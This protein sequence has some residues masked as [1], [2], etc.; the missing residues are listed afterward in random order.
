MPNTLKASS[1]TPESSLHTAKGKAAPESSRGEQLQELEEALKALAN[2]NQFFETLIRGLPGIFYCFN[3]KLQVLR[4]NRNVETVTG[5]TE[6]EVGSISLLTLFKG[7]DKSLIRNSIKDVFVNGEGLA[8]STIVTKDGR[9]IPYMFTGVSTRI[10]GASYLMGM[11]LD[12]SARKAAEQ[13]LRE[14][15]ALYR[16]LGERITEGVVL[17]HK[18]RFLFANEAAAS[19]FGYTREEFLAKTPEFMAAEPFRPYFLELYQ[20]LESGA[21]EERTFQA[22]C[23]HKLGNELWVEGKAN[24]ITWKGKP[25]LL[26]TARDVTET[27]LRELSMQEEAE[28]LRRENVNLRSSMRDRYR[29]G[30]I[31]GKSTAMQEVYELILNAAAGSANVIIYGESGTGKE[32]VARAIH[33]MS[34]RADQPFVPVNCAAIPANLLESEFFGSRKGAFTGAHS[35]KEGFLD[36]ANGG[37]LFLD[38]VGELD[39][40]LQV[41]LL[42]AIEGGGYTPVGGNAVKFS[43]FRIIAATNRNLLEQARAGKMREDFF[44]RIHIIP[45]NLP[46]LRQRRDDI[47]L[48]AEHFMKVYSGGQGQAVLPGKVLDDLVA[49]DWPG[50]VRELQNVIQR[51]LTVNRLDFISPEPVQA[52]APLSEAVENGADLRGATE[53]VEKALIKKALDQN[54][55]HKSR[56]AESLG[57]SR[58]TLFRK[59]RRLGLS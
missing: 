42:R 39:I 29:F 21:A 16:L 12:I 33:K 10:N 31:I 47:P 25:S 5:Y 9:K 18:N 59:M 57:I 13:S 26:L 27:K 11:G 41:K 7:G 43:D 14:S 8:E 56:T 38:E 32:L 4:W 23:L 24:F 2:E 50:N 46:P 52:K 34:K 17:A 49:Y 40:M 1:K 19:M 36:Q 30:N 3:D 22:R 48:L 54:R 35:N 58:K 53:N 20:A 6:E 37:T 28:N 55:G 15:E 51:Y 45:I 44:F